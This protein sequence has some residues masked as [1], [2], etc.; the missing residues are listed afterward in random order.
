MDLHRSLMDHE[1]SLHGPLGFAA[2]IRG[3]YSPSFSVHNDIRFTLSA[4]SGPQPTLP[5]SSGPLPRAGRVG[6][7]FSQAS[8]PKLPNCVLFPAARVGAPFSQAPG[9]KLPNCALPAPAQQHAWEYPFC[10][11]QA[12]NSRIQPRAPPQQ[13]RRSALF[14]SSRPHTPEL[15]TPARGPAAR[16]GAPFRKLQAP[17]SRIV[18][19]PATRGLPSSTCGST[20]SASFSPKLPN[21]VLPRMAGP[22]PATRMGVAFS[23]A[24][25]HKLPNCVL[26]RAAGPFPAARMAGPSRSTLFAN[27]RPQTP[28]LCT[29][30]RGGQTPELCTPQARVKV[31]FSQASGP[32]LPNC[33]LPRS[34]AIPPRLQ[35]VLF[36]TLLGLGDWY[37]Q[38]PRTE[39]Q[40]PS[41]KP[42]R[43]NLNRLFKTATEPNRTVTFMSMRRAVGHGS[44]REPPRT[45]LVRAPSKPK[46]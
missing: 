15:Y 37:R 33:V 18:Y 32:K 20:L 36:S 34:A 38:E 31:P 40:E 27:F 35:N 1:F 11:L 30:P 46:P 43:M 24:P 28:E 12:P 10:K 45:A 16:V 2:P 19:S 6:V 44:I 13:T 14:A 39:P 5:C 21:C 17:N 42:N 9:P 22:S 29:P 25:G 23:Q 4:V 26:P 3:L 41:E 8:S 7:P